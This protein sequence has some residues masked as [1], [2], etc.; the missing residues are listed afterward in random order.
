MERIVI[1][2]GGIMGSS[3]AY[4]LALAG[5]ASAVTVLE[6][7]PTYAFAASPRA[8]GGIRLQHAVRENVEMSLYGDQV[9]SAF[10]E[11]VRGGKVEFDPQFRRRGYLYQVHGAAGVAALEANV[12]MQRELGVEV[13]ILDVAELRRRYPSFRFTN[14]DC[15]ALSP[16]G[17]VD[18]YAALMGF[19]KA[20]EG[21]GIVYV[22]D[23]LV[24]L[25]L[26]GGLMKQARLA[27]GGSLP[28]DTL[29]NVANCWAPEIC[30]MVGMSVPIEP[31]RRQ[32]FYF[33]AQQQIEPIPA[34]RHMDGLAVRIHQDGYIVGATAPQAGF[35]WELDHEVFESTLWPQLA[36]QSAAFEAIKLKSAWGG[37]YDMN[38]LDGNPIIDRFD[39]VPN[40]IL[41]AG[42]SGH[43]LMH[44][45]A[46][47]RAVK[48][49]I[50]D[51]G[52]RTI[53]LSRLGWRRV[54]ENQPLADDG[55]TA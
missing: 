2:G 53:D 25:E 27:S 54:V 32:Q 36:E 16:D 6:P 47:G 44:A 37:H 4:H 43:G 15:A 31:V 1:A 52:F 14:V 39:K 42:F 24:G 7:D 29:V 49:M 45:P 20:A 18:P 21:L 28:V 40:F 51:G 12:R 5:P 10:A 41:A 48:E 33:L 35:K 17:Q 13:H 26:A 50:L 11:H 46:V 34:M 22:K 38:R 30:A 55:P 9:Y 23:R 8:V 19:R 3:I